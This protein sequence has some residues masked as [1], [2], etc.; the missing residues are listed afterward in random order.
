MSGSDQPP[1]TGPRPQVR[2]VRGAV[3]VGVAASLIVVITGVGALASLSLVDVPGPFIAQA[4]IS[5]VATAALWAGVVVAVLTVAPLSRTIATVAL[6]ATL[7]QPVLLVVAGGT[8]LPFFPV[9]LPL[10]LSAVATAAAL[11]VLW[12]PWRDAPRRT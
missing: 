10:F 6:A 7:A 9:A 11:I 1:L 3:A 8:P 5:I 2:D 4:T 12:Y